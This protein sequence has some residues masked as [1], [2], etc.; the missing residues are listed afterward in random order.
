M[1]PLHPW[2]DLWRIPLRPS[3]P[4]SPSSP[5]TLRTRRGIRGRIIIR[6]RIDF[7]SSAR[8]R[9]SMRR[10]TRTP[11]RTCARSGCQILWG[12]QTRFLQ[13]AAADTAHILILGARQVVIIHGSA[14]IFTGRRRTQRTDHPAAEIHPVHHWGR[15]GT[16]TSPVIISPGTG[17]WGNLGGVTVRISSPAISSPAPAVIFGGSGDRGVKDGAPAAGIAR[18]SSTPATNPAGSVVTGGERVYEL[19]GAHDF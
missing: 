5:S 19:V 12:R 6:L 13:G 9:T 4:P 7:S 16:P 14:R 1:H 18:V 8:D 15:Y 2:I 17:T 11:P 10:G 3:T